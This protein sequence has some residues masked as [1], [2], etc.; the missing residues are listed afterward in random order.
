[1]YFLGEGRGGVLVLRFKFIVAIFQFTWTFT[2]N[3]TVIGKGSYKRTMD[4]EKYIQESDPFIEQDISKESFNRNQEPLSCITN[5]V[6]DPKASCIDIVKEKHARKESRVSSVGLLPLEDLLSFGN[7]CH[8]T[9]DQSEDFENDIMF[10]SNGRTPMKGRLPLSNG[11]GLKSCGRKSYCDVKLGLQEIETSA[12][13]LWLNESEIEREKVHLKDATVTTTECNLDGSLIKSDVDENRKQRVMFMVSD[14]ELLPKKLDLKS[15]EGSLCEDADLSVRDS[16]NPFLCD[17]QVDDNWVFDEQKVGDGKSSDMFETVS[18]LA[19]EV[20][21]SDV[22]DKKTN[23]EL[24]I[25]NDLTGPLDDEHFIPSCDIKK[26]L[27]QDEKEFIE[28]HCLDVFP[29]ELEGSRENN[30]E[31][32]F[33]A[34]TPY[35]LQMFKNIPRESAVTEQSSDC[36]SSKSPA[37]IIHTFNLGMGRSIH[38]PVLLADSFKTPS[39]LSNRTNEPGRDLNDNDSN[40]SPGTFFGQ[41]S[42]YM[43][44]L[45]MKRNNPHSRPVF[46]DDRTV[47]TPSPTPGVP[48]IDDI[49]EKPHEEAKNEKDGVNDAALVQV[50]N[51][52]KALLFKENKAVDGEV[53]G[54]SLKEKNN[55]REYLL[56]NGLLFEPQQD[57][58]PT[59]YGEVLNHHIMIKNLTCYGILCDAVLNSPKSFF[60]ILQKDALFVPAKGQSVFILKFEPKRSVDETKEELSCVVSFS[61]RF[62]DGKFCDG[63]SQMLNLRQNCFITGHV[64]DARDSFDI[65]VDGCNLD[66]SDVSIMNFQS[67]SSSLY[68]SPGKVLGDGL[69]WKCIEITNKSKCENFI[70]KLSL[71]NKELSNSRDSNLTRKLFDSIKL[72]DPSSFAGLK[73]ELKGLNRV[74]NLLK[75]D[76]LCDSIQFTMN[77]HTRIKK[78]IY[79]VALPANLNS[80]EVAFGHGK[81]SIAS[82]SDFFQCEV[83]VEVPLVHETVKRLKA[84]VRP[85]FVKIRV[86]NDLQKCKLKV[87]KGKSA[88]QKIPLKNC[89]NSLGKISLSFSKKETGFSVCPSSILLSP[90]EVKDIL[91]T[92][93]ETSS[94]QGEHMDPK[95]EFNVL[96]IHTLPPCGSYKLTFYAEYDSHVATPSPSPSPLSLSLACDKPILNW[97]CLEQ[98]SASTDYSY[99]ELLADN[100]RT[101]NLLNK[102]SAA[103]T[104]MAS[105]KM[106]KCSLN[107]GAEESL[108]PYFFVDNASGELSNRIS[109]HLS[110]KESVA[111]HIY[112]DLFSLKKMRLPS[113]A[114]ADLVLLRESDNKPFS[115]PLVCFHGVDCVDLIANESITEAS[116]DMVDPNT[117]LYTYELPARG[118][119]SLLIGLSRSA[120]PKE[121][122]FPVLLRNFGSRAAFVK[123]TLNDSRR[124]H[125]GKVCCLWGQSEF[126]ISGNSEVSVPFI[127]EE[128]SDIEPFA[129]DAI[130][131]S[132]SFYIVNELFRQKVCSILSKGVKS[133]SG[134]PDVSSLSDELLSIAN[135]Q[136]TDQHIDNEN[137]SIEVKTENADYFDC[138]I[139]KGS[140]YALKID[141]KRA[142]NRRTSFLP[143]PSSTSLLERDTCPWQ[144]SPIEIFLSRPTYDVENNSSFDSNSSSLLKGSSSIGSTGMSWFEI[145]NN[146]ASASDI[147][148]ELIWPAY[149][150]TV[151]PKKL[152]LQRG[153]TGRVWVR[154]KGDIKS[155]PSGWDGKIHVLGGDGRDSFVYVHLRNDEI[156][157]NTTPVSSLNDLEN[158]SMSADLQTKIIEFPCVEEGSSSFSLRSWEVENNSDE[159]CEFS[160]KPS[161]PLKH[162]FSSGNGC[163]SSVFS[164]VSDKN[165]DLKGKRWLDCSTGKHSLVDIIAPHSRVAVHFAFAPYSSGNFEQH[166]VVRLRSKANQIPPQIPKGRYDLNDSLLSFNNR[167]KPTNGSNS[168]VSCTVL[169]L[170]GSCRVDNDVEHRRLETVSSNLVERSFSQRMSSS[171]GEISGVASRRQSAESSGKH[172]SNSSRSFKQSPAVNGSFVVENDNIG[173]SL[174]ES[175]I[176]LANRVSSLEQGEI[177]N[178]TMRNMDKLSLGNG[179]LDPALLL[180][181]SDLVNKSILSQSL[182]P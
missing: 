21:F 109:F 131:G 86:P 156:V 126:I 178:A 41:R 52:S 145:Q 141:I 106:R 38:S 146:G 132:I 65:K 25:P 124:R 175:I 31:F 66:K 56:E 123:I 116:S 140:S 122:G 97:G 32:K 69:K 88:T 104:L 149:F 84:I 127:V 8:Q 171:F 87:S 173:S 42:N 35:V 73:T 71:S 48:L 151:T 14:K 33:E 102:S 72:C 82:D 163:K 15:N 152:F 51:V 55:S 85:S 44:N 53:C 74:E 28:E 177:R 12:V 121:V 96:E 159:L 2:F 92:F 91:I 19:K 125:A 114:N 118:E 16:S 119:D 18:S 59:F 120:K 174:H 90:G 153:E 67:P 112:C 134:M 79:V 139:F 40:E 180:G 68:A 164:C 27:D 158:R 78:Y 147:S 50:N 95:S 30:E 165:S 182:L 76:N 98:L 77:A 110:P 169:L 154:F 160:I 99:A 58:N 37:Q 60:K 103:F 128:G 130:L 64:E 70:V 108:A 138:E 155:I 34:A 105:I 75:S 150:I 115:I 9:D 17:D 83:R 166:W 1:M 144:L 148:Y 26:I 162:S 62:S 29:S 107:R 5:T 100:S 167:E 63:R 80:T 10:F 111:V 161:G 81:D 45:S 113:C 101:I 11:T 39:S 43:G 49:G 36:R 133:K 168:M 136:G 7:E 46:F 181:T 6:P 176:D 22:P 137:L 179:S 20:K 57:L 3:L 93:S 143:L 47:E 172:S 129:G 170:Q 54:I 61:A 157:N 94:D 142:F 89:G 135:W 24:Q 4:F 23:D 13:E 117:K